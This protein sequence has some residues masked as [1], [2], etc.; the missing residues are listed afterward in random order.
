MY[1]YLNYKIVWTG[2]FTQFDYILKSHHSQHFEIFPHD[3]QYLH[4][5]SSGI[6]AIH[7]HLLILS[8]IIEK[9]K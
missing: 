4:I 5:L 8:L 6:I 3:V 7:L 2:C 9:K 1:I